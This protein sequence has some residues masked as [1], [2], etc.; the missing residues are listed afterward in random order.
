M[1][2]IDSRYARALDSVVSEHRLDR[3]AVQQQ[4]TSFA[5]TLAQSADLREVLENPSIPEA[6]KLRLLDALAG[7]LS[8]DKVVRNFIALIASHN[9]LN[10]FS[11]IQA[12]YAALLDEAGTVVEV[13][14]A[15]AS[16]LSD[17]SKAQL[18]AQV[19]KLAGG[20]KI[21]P[22]YTQDASLLGG[23]VVRIGSKVYDGSV[24]TQLQ[25]LKQSLVSSLA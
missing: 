12:A 22:T 3:V 14:G 4:L 5:E 1:P 23:A 25:Q 24:K 2:A 18:E 11:E 13:E 20:Q 21:Q 6:Q 9:R 19:A 16:A 15:S 7:K 10:E 17:S 8:L